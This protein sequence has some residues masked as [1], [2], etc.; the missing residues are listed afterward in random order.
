M[1]N[2]SSAPFL[3]S[4]WEY[5]VMARTQGGTAAVVTVATVATGATGQLLRRYGKLSRSGAAA[6]V[7]KAV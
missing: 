3:I 7:Y 1:I 4:F 5:L 6:V 2:R